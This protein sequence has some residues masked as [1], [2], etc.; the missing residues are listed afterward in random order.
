MDVEFAH[1]AI[2][3]SVVSSLVVVADFHRVGASLV[4]ALTREAAM[5]VNVHDHIGQIDPHNVAGVELSP[6]LRV[7]EELALADKLRER[8]IGI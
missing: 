3:I 5:R 1:H 2:P 6:E 4:F 7:G 8:R